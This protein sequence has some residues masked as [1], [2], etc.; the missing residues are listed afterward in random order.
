VYSACQWTGT[1]VM[2]SWMESSKGFT[3]LGIDNGS[4]ECHSLLK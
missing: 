4:E 1:Q 3:R 2:M